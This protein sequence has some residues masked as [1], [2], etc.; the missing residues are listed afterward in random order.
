[1]FNDLFEEQ[2]RWVERVLGMVAALVG[3]G[4]LV[5]V[6]WIGK[7][8][9]HSAHFRQTIPILIGG[10]LVSVYS[11]VISRRLLRSHNRPAHLLSGPALIFVGLFVAAGAVMPLIAFRELGGLAVEGIVLGS[12]AIILGLRRL[13]R[14]P[15]VPPNEIDAA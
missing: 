5:V 15:A 12:A 2:P 14:S 8:D 4:G 3:V 11:L 10:A 1:V 7:M 9:S 13:R 6:A